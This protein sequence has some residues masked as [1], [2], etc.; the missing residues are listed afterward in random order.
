MTCLLAALVPLQGLA[1]GMI[2]AVGPAHTLKSVATAQTPL[3]TALL[4]GDFRRAPVHI[5]AP[6]THV[7]TAFGHFHATQG[8][9]RHHHA[10]GDVSVVLADGNAL[11]SNGDGEDLSISPTLALFVALIPSAMAPLPA[12]PDATT[13]SHAPWAPQTHHPALPEH[14]PRVA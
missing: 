7:A 14:P 13:A 3:A 9:L 6:S 12:A 5:E 10:C 11:Q 8:P 1:A 2:A 4:L